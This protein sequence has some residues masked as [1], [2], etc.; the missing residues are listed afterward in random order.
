MSLAHTSAFRT[1]M[2]SCGVMAAPAWPSAVK[3]TWLLLSATTLTLTTSSGSARMERVAKLW[4]QM[5]VT[6]MVS[7]RGCT[8]GPPADSE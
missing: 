4:G 2:A 7:R 1:M 6:K 8:I 5:G 3:T